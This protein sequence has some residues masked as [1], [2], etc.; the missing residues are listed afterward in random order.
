MLKRQN[1]LITGR[2]FST[3]ML[4]RIKKKEVEQSLTDIL[5]SN[6]WIQL[7]GYMVQGNKYPLKAM[8]ENYNNASEA[9]LLKRYLILK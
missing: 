9:V 4:Q 8:P 6:D 1:A 2:V 7:F 3:E 5:Y